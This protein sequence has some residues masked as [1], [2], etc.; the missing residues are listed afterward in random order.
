VASGCTPSKND[1]IE[2]HIPRAKST[3]QPWPD[4]PPVAVDL[5]KLDA[6]RDVAHLFPLH[7]L[8]ELKGE[9]VG[10]IQSIAVIGDDFYI[11][12]TGQSA[13]WHFN[14]DGE[15][16]GQIGRKGQ[17]PGEY[18]N[19]LSIKVV[20]DG[21]LG[22]SDSFQGKILVFN[23]DGQFIA[24]YN[25]WAGDQRIIPSLAF[26]WP[27]KDTLILGG[28]SS[29]NQ[30]APWHVRLRW[31]GKD[32]SV[33]NGFG[34]RSDPLLKHKLGRFSLSCFAIVGGNIWVGSPY[35]TD[36]NVYDMNGS[37]LG[38]IE[39]SKCL[40][41][42]SESDFDSFPKDPT[43]ARAKRNALFKR[44]HNFSIMQVGSYVIVDHGRKISLYDLKGHLL[45][46][47][48]PRF[49]MG[50][51]LESKGNFI[52][53]PLSAGINGINMTEEEKDYLINS[54]GISLESAEERN[55][56]IRVGIAAEYLR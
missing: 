48:I 26:L 17:G 4:E 11:L 41:P 33:L 49:K 25:Q 7:S 3:K 15:F 53:S 19:P 12:D 42:L 35:L 40:D 56:F 39:K 47:S 9:V 10:Y 23:A 18:Q 34:E 29:Y 28:F 13:V 21:N 30:E 31:S 20:F 8:V 37:Y 5:A 1:H 22:V 55:P 27:E 16:L 43:K 50:F 51:I 46:D 36:I 52:Y 38:D 2:N 24:E 45:R 14:S 54:L 6:A 44:T 32:F